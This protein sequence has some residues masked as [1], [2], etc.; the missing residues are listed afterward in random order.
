MAL[1]TTNLQLDV[2]AAALSIS[3]SNVVLSGVCIS[4]NVNMYGLDST[5]CPGA[6]PSA[7]LSNLQ[8]TPH[9]QS[10]FRNYNHSAPAPLNYVETR[11]NTSSTCPI[12]SSAYVWTSGTTV[13]ESYINGYLLYAD[14]TGVSYA[15]QGWY[16]TTGDTS[17]Y[18]VWYTGG[19]PPPVW[20]SSGVC[21]SLTSF[22]ATDGPD[23][24]SVEACLNTK[25]ST[26]YH[27]G[28]GTYPANGDTVYTDSGGSTYATDGWYKYVSG[29][30]FVYGISGS[31]VIVTGPNTC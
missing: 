2:I 31:G 7:R 12:N 3:T 14:S 28:A 11:R 30:S 13:Y 29:T 19:F 24:S 4:G 25:Y 21:S 17:T 8:S 22:S 16:S 15:T 23:G 20:T 1:P 6:T 26:F 5:Y 9:H 18:Y 10:Y 27:D